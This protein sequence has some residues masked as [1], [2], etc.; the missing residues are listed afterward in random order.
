MTHHE[1]CRAGHD[2]ARERD[3]D[4]KSR[5]GEKGASDCRPLDELGT[6]GEREG[7]LVLAQGPL[8]L[9]HNGRSDGKQDLDRYRH[10]GIEDWHRRVEVDPQDDLV[11]TAFDG[12][13]GSCASKISRSRSHV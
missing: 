7:Q 2:G 6:G 1:G 10:Q 12:D 9:A 5:E 4:S 11:G 8:D 13:F 3:E